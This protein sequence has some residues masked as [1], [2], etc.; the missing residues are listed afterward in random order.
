M[1]TQKFNL[2]INS[3]TGRTLIIDT[4]DTELKP[5]KEYFIYKYLPLTNSK[6]GF[7]WKTPKVQDKFLKTF[8]TNFCNKYKEPNPRA[9]DWHAKSY[10]EK[11]KWENKTDI[12][13]EQ[14]H[15]HHS[16]NM[17]S[18]KS[19]ME[20]LET[21]F[22]LPETETAILKYGF[23]ATEY[24]IGIFVL[25]AGSRELVAV[26][27]MKKYLNANNIIYKNEF[28]EARWVLRFKINLTKEIHNK[29]LNQVS[30]N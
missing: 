30:K 3:I 12:E 13:K 17:Y 11:A 5:E 15:R 9:Y 7:I 18:K 29:I 28:S 24:G 16:G 6:I 21:N 2:L 22:N 23:Y 14:A 10:G 25:F 19:L 8:I 26:K 20:Q 27:E 4:I 1:N